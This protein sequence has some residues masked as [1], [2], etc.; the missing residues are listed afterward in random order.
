MSDEAKVWWQ[1]RA[2]WGAL[3]VIVAQGLRLAGIELGEAEQ[4]Q[5]VDAALNIVTALGAALAIYGRVRA[6]KAVTLTKP[7]EGA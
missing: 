4:Q 7:K 2:I 6:R 3:I 1:S 5:L